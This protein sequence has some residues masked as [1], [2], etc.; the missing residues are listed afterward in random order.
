MNDGIVL[1][2]GPAVIMVDVYDDGRLKRT[3]TFHTNPGGSATAQAREFAAIH[4]A[5]GRK[6]TGRVPVQKKGKKK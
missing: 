4:E 1:V 6:V 3:V 5:R 2:D